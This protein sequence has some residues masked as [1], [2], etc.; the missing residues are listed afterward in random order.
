MNLVKI[1]DDFKLQKYG[2]FIC[3]KCDADIPD[4]REYKY[5]DV[6][7]YWYDKDHLDEYPWI[8]VEGMGYGWIWRSNRIRKHCKFLQRRAIRR[9]AQRFMKLMR[10]KTLVLIYK[11]DGVEYFGFMIGDYCYVQIRVSNKELD[12]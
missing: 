5:I 6:C 11:F 1:I 12:V 7:E 3:K 8:D 4:I 9:Y 2:V 10:E